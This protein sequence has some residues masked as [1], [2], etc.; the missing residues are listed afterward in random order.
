MLAYSGVGL[1]MS[2]A[3]V[4]QT[5]GLLYRR[6]SACRRRASS[7]APTLQAPADCKSA[8]QQT[9]GLRY[10]IGVAWFKVPLHVRNANGGSPGSPPRLFG[11]SST[12]RARSP[13]LLG[14]R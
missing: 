11:R 7:R 9:G 14:C 3:E 2:R 6:L 12:R 10:D 1:S 4:A 5:S 13:A 8:I